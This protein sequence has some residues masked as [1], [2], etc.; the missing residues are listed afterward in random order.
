MS[1]QTKII[2]GIG[3]AVLTVLAFLYF[4]KKKNA[5]GYHLGTP[6]NTIATI[7]EAVQKELAWHS[8]GESLVYQGV[9]YTVMGG[10]W[11]V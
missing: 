10:Q 6:V 4:T 11:T 3:V 7:P 2:I 5:N 1:K 8:D 9:K